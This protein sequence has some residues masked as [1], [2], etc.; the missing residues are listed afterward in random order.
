MTDPF[1]EPSP[2]QPG[3]KNYSRLTVIGLVVALA[4][5]LYLALR[6]PPAPQ[7]IN[8]L[9]PEFSAQAAAGQK[10]FNRICALCHGL[11]ASGGPKAPSLIR[12]TYKPTRHADQAIYLAIRKGVRQHHW[13]FGNMPPRP[14]IKNDQIP[15]L[16]AFIR[17]TQRANGIR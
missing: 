3:S 6:E 4:A 11:N 7:K 16:I 5:V 10:I 15:A 12:P 1:P 14:E 9:L 8:V 17:E 2:E 13:N